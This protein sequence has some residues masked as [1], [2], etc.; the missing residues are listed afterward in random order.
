MRRI[1]LAGLILAAIALILTSVALTWTVA[2]DLATRDAVEVVAT[3]P[4]GEQAAGKSLDWGA[5][6]FLLLAMALGTLGI[7]LVMAL[8]EFIEALKIKWSNSKDQG[9]E[10]K[11]EELKLTPGNNVPPPGPSGPL[12]Q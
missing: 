6:I 9:G 10:Q 2:W 12:L 4:P 11:P 5:R 3:A 1:G 7:P 8:R